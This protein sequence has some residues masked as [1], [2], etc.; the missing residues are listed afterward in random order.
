MLIC[1]FTWNI[2][3]Q[4]K[5][6]QLQHF[7]CSFGIWGIDNIKSW[8]LSRIMCKVILR[9][10]SAIEFTIKKQGFVMSG[11]HVTCDMGIWPV[12]LS[13]SQ[14]F[15]LSYLFT[16]HPA[17]SFS[18]FL[19]SQTFHLIYLFSPFP[20]EGEAPSTQVG[21]GSSSRWKWG[22]QTFR[23]VLLRAHWPQCCGVA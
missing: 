6:H 5:F 16:L 13:T 12:L 22:K 19:S 9:K 2:V 20:R 18:S 10:Q 8:H 17:C 4:K 1:G 14:C 3:Q 21:T 7:H 11:L 15:W 23:K